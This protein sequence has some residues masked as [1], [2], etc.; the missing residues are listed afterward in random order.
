MN[1]NIFGKKFIIRRKLTK[2]RQI[3]AEKCNFIIEG[4]FTDSKIADIIPFIH[5]GEKPT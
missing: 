4:E 5:K 1:W 3:N 2:I